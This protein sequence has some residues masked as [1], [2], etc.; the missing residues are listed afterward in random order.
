M[1]STRNDWYASYGT[2]TEIN[3]AFTAYAGQSVYEYGELA[4]ELRRAFAFL[5]KHG[6]RR[7]S[8][9]SL[10]KLLTYADRLDGGD[11]QP[12]DCPKVIV[13]EVPFGFDEETEVKSGGPIAIAV[14]LPDSRMMLAVHGEKRRIRLGKCMYSY[15]N[16]ALNVR[17][18]VWIHQDNTDAQKFALALGMKPWRMNDSGALAFAQEAPREEESEAVAY[19]P[20]EVLEHMMANEG[21]APTVRRSRPSSIRCDREYALPERSF[22]PSE[23][24]VSAWGAI[25]HPTD[26][27]G[28]IERLLATPNNVWEIEDGDEDEVREY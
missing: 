22:L 3:P 4:G 5:R 9:S 17:P 11:V 12:N 19:A 25:P 8:A 15:A 14:V 26:D 21:R 6:D 16:Y 2:P 1:P 18:T 27:G 10:M 28:R 13:A 20:D 24:E 23:G 7:Y